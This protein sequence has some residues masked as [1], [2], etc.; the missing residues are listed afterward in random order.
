MAY[1]M[2]VLWARYISTDAR[3]NW[4]DPEYVPT[5]EAGTYH[6][7][8]TTAPTRSQ[9]SDTMLDLL[10]AVAGVAV[11]VDSNLTTQMKRDLVVACETAL[12]RKGTRIELKNVAASMTGGVAD[13]WTPGTYQ[14]SVIVPDG[15]PSPGYGDW[16]PPAA[17]VAS[18]RPWLFATARRI[19][20][21]MFP[22]W[23]LMGLGYSQFR[24]GF[25]AAGEPV[26]VSGARLNLLAN[27]HFS[28][29]AVGTPT[30]WFVTGTGTLNQNTTDG[31][32]NQEFTAN[33]AEVDLTGAAAGT[34]RQFQQGT[35]EFN[36]QK[37]HVFEFDYKYT[38]SQNA[39]VIT[40][41]ILDGEGRYWDP[42]EETWHAS[43]FTFAVPPSSTRTR[44]S[45]EIV[46]VTTSS[47][48]TSS[49]DFQ[50]TNGF[51]VRIK[52][53]SDGT[54]TTQTSYKLYRVA[55]YEKNSRTQ[56]LAAQG[57]R[58]FWAPLQ[59]VMTE[60][61]DSTSGSD[62][63]VYP[64]NA[65][66]SGVLES[67]SGLSVN[68]YHP[69][70][71]SRGLRVHRT[72][73]NLVKGSNIF[74]GDWTANNVTSDA[75][76]SPR[77]NAPST[78]GRSLTATGASPRLFQS[79]LVANPSSRTYIA[80][81][82]LKKSSGTSSDV[83]LSL[84]SNT[85]KEQTF[86]LG[87]D[88]KLCAMSA[89]AFGGGDTNPLEFRI[90]LG[91][92]DQVLLAY[93]SYCYEVTGNTDILYPPVCQTGSGTSGVVADTSLA[94]TTVTTL[95]GKYKCSVV[96]GSLYLTIVP[97]YGTL[98]T[99]PNGVIFDVAE[100]AAQNRVVLRVTSGAL[101]LRRWDDSGTN[102]AASLSLVYTS[103]PTTSQATWRRDEA[104]VIRAS[105]DE[106][107]T[108]LSAGNGNA[109]HTI[110]GG[111][112]PNNDSLTA[113]AVGNDYNGANPWDGMITGLE[114]VQLGAITT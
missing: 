24:A 18:F 8:L 42:D 37:T 108:S 99:V 25:S 66:R 2:D 63:L 85:G 61:T 3:T 107:Q 13:S 14:F 52:V 79:S 20:G 60:F 58:T 1:E 55:F 22:A 49:T 94:N 100:G 83:T 59:D 103:D 77:V 71:S 96:R 102:H 81:V 39:S 43:A 65:D 87:S 92:T 23:S 46:P 4:L 33:C 17:T 84:R 50:G 68:P 29:W 91:S 93:S 109:V 44:Y 10:C 31:S 32:I 35:S 95:L 21:K 78:G 28:S 112:A 41:Q 7:N 72:A 80:G 64:V 30:T 16:V 97:T 113:I 5:E 12:K 90:A 51:I 69:A 34:Y 15:V 53:Q 62:T 45:T 27:E 19:L 47:L 110:S 111:W 48:S 106:R 82:W 104:L 105:W 56:D 86:T 89:Q 114:V 11:P 98:S 54:A 38:N 57:E 67:T 6:A 76:A 88:W 40:V 9:I 26:L 101:E 70:I 36:N 73:T 74:G 75:S